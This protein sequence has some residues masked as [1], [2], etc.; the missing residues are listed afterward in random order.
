MRCDFNFQSEPIQIISATSRAIIERIERF[1]QGIVNDLKNG[2]KIQVVVQSRRNWTDCY[3]DNERYTKKIHSPSIKYR[4]QQENNFI[5]FSSCATF[6]NFD[7]HSIFARFNLLPITDARCRHIK[8][9][10]SLSI[11]FYMLGEIH[12]M[13]LTNTKCT[14]R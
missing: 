2:Q 3:V 1:I 9:T 8:S 5:L 6:Y 7:F 10:F 11:I 13:L 4:F 12:Q 14:L